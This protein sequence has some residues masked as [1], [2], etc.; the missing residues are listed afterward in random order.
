MVVV[1][2]SCVVMVVWCDGGFVM[3]WWC[4]VMVVL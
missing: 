1:W 3:W 4:G 2:W